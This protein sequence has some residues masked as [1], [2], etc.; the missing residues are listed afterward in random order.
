MIDS[1]RPVVKPI[2]TLCTTLAG[3]QRGNAIYKV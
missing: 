1:V 2:A 3:K